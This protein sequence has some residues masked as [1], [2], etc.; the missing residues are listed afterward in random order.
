MGLNTRPVRHSM[1]STLMD[2]YSVEIL[3]LLQI[4][5]NGPACVF[6]INTKKK[7]LLLSILEDFTHF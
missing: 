5:L 2:S 1:L 3:P 4:F 6:I 7:Q